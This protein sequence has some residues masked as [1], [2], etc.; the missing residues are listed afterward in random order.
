MD[1]PPG[2]WEYLSPEFHALIAQKVVGGCCPLMGHEAHSEW[3]AC[4]ACH[5]LDSHTGQPHHQPGSS[6][7]CSPVWMGSLWQS[8]LIVIYIGMLTNHWHV[9]MKGRLHPRLAI[10][11]LRDTIIIFGIYL[12]Y[13]CIWKQAIEMTRN[14]Y[15]ME[16]V[17]PTW[18]RYWQQ[19]RSGLSGQTE[20]ILGTWG[21]ERLE[22]IVLLLLL[23]I[24]CT[25]TCF[26][27]APNP[28]F[29]KVY[30]SITDLYYRDPYHLLVTI[31]FVVFDFNRDSTKMLLIVAQNASCVSFKPFVVRPRDIHVKR[32]V[33]C[34]SSHIN[35]P[36]V[37]RFHHKS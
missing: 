31:L 29:I 14:V 20:L 22:V 21:N 15:F 1:H 36:L 17:S 32:A 27:I 8:S 23:F 9:C 16:F 3:A 12:C 37:P 26:T 18:I 25:D 24:L 6:W 2:S 5:R 10:V 30:Q 35:R 19:C 33:S 11:I 4:S 13:C 7:A 34:A 28:L